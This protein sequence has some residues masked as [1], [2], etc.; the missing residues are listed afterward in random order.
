[1]IKLFEEFYTMF[2]IKKSNKKY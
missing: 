1:M 2:W